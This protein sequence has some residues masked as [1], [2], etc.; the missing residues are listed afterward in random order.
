MAVVLDPFAGIPAQS[1]EL[2]LINARRSLM[3]AV[4]RTKAKK[5][6]ICIHNKKMSGSPLPSTPATPLNLRHLEHFFSFERLFL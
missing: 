1:V 2:K 5:T 4:A 3:K 6:K